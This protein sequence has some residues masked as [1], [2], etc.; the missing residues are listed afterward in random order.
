[1]IDNPLMPYP[2]TLSSITLA[3]IVSKAIRDLRS[4]PRKAVPDKDSQYTVSRTVD[5]ASY[6]IWT[7]ICKPLDPIAI[8]SLQGDG[9]DTGPSNV[10]LTMTDQG[11]VI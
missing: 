5:L 1:M 7:E 6:V 3:L 8:I 2:S 9:E 10:S 11:K 4:K